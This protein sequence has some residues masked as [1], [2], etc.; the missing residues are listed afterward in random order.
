MRRAPGP[1]RR[2]VGTPRGFGTVKTPV[3]LVDGVEP[4][5]PEQSIKADSSEDVG[6]F[7][8]LDSGRSR[9]CLTNEDWMMCR[10]AQIDDGRPEDRGED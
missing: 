10:L 6:N 1:A 4:H 2:H 3:S 9:R 5:K 7:R 8:G